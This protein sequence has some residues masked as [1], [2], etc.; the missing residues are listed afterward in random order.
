LRG[1]RRDFIRLMT[2]SALAAALVPGYV[3]AEDEKA[4]TGK[5]EKLKP[6]AVEVPQRSRAETALALMGEYG[7]CCSGVL[8]AYASEFGIEGNLVG[9]LG[10]GMAGG[11]GGLG[12]VCGAVS[13]AILVIGL[14]TTNEE[15]IHDM[16]AGLKSMEIVRDFV[17]RFEERHSSIQCRDLIGCDISSTEKSAA[18]MKNGAFADCPKFVASAAAILDEMFPGG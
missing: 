8:G 5:E 18:A 14:K 12:N 2:S 4:E 1:D 16:Q 13:G 7:S 15:N 9:G 10:R 11:I 3:S 6:G 17:A